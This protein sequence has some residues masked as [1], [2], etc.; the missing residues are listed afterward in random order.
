[1]TAQPRKGALGFMTQF[2]IRKVRPGRGNFFGSGFHGLNPNL[3]QLGAGGA[4]RTGQPDTLPHRPLA[5]IPSCSQAARLT[6]ALDNGCPPENDSFSPVRLARFVLSRQP[7]G[8]LARGA[9][10]ASPVPFG[11]PP[12]VSPAPLGPSPTGVGDSLLRAGEKVAKPDE[13]SPRRP[14][15]G[16]GGKTFYG[17]E[18]RGEVPKPA[19]SRGTPARRS[20]LIKYVRQLVRRLPQG[21]RRNVRVMHGHRR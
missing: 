2:H 10:T 18:D 16:S 11:A 3:N 8:T 9:A 20:R 4:G 5:S 17:G 12:K 7:G 19:A 21:F 14:G 6:H 15:E 1:M 13:V